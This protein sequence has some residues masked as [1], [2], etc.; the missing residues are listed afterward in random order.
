MTPFKQRSHS[1]VTTL[2]RDIFEVMSRN[3]QN[4]IRTANTA[5]SKILRLI[6]FEWSKINTNPSRHEIGNRC[7]IIERWSRF[8]L[9]SHLSG[10]NRIS[11]IPT[12]A[13]QVERNL[14][15]FKLTHFSRGNPD[16]SIISDCLGVRNFDLK[17]V[18]YFQTE[19]FILK[20]FKIR[21]SYNLCIGHIILR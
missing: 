21:G 15:V 12:I 11:S 10:R 20:A 1:R 18:D 13:K 19:L 4:F 8:Q 3:A 16:I 9:V 17:A 6:T 2:E 7:R 5:K 14:Q